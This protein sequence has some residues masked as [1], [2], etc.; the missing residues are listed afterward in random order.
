MKTEDLVQ[1]V[2]IE[3]VAVFDTVG[4]MGFPSFDD[5][6]KMMDTFRFADLDLSSKVKHGLHALALDEMREIFSPTLW[7]DR[8]QV[9]QELFPGAHAD[10]GGGYPTTDNESGLSDVTY[11]WI[12]N[13]L[14]KLNVQ[15]SLHPDLIIMPDAMGIAHKEW[16]QGIFSKTPIAPRQFPQTIKDKSIDNIQPRLGKS[17]KWDPS[18]PLSPYH[19]TNWL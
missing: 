16:L 10:V 18:E 15:F 5:D 6:K 12:K 13:H 4:A 8:D 11:H 19:P 3:C 2:S 1:G 9:I 17:V 14:E 7:N